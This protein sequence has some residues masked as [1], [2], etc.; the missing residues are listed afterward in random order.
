[1]KNKQLLIIGAVVLVLVVAVGI[2][3]VTKKKAAQEGT[4]PEITTEE[5]SVT[6]K[7]EDIGLSLEP[8]ANNQEVMM[9]I[10]DLTK[11]DSLEY[12]MNYDAIVDG[13]TVPR[14]A[15]GS[16]EVKPGEKEI[17]RK[18]TIGTCSANVCRFDKGVTKVKFII[19][20]NLKTGETGVVEQDLS[21]E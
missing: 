12:E 20:L 9:K 19:R 15:I 21:L 14:G 11:F 2:F 1:M 16:A 13:E 4:G 3:F 7:P 18:I 17:S 5:Q 6:L 10:T 8:T